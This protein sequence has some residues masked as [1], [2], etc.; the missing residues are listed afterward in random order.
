MTSRVVSFFERVFPIPAFLDVPQVGLD[1]S[2]A[3]IKYME[4]AHKGGRLSVKRFGEEQLPEG[5]MVAGGHIVKPDVLVDLLSKIHKEKKV[6]HAVLSLPEEQAYIVRLQV[7]F[8]DPSRI[9]EALELQLEEHIPL[10]P[11][12]VVF[13]YSILREPA[14]E[15]GTYDIA[16]AALPRPVVDAYLDLCVRAGIH[17]VGFEIETHAVSRAVVPV[18]S[19]ASTMVVDLGK[20]RTGI[21]IVLGQHVLFTSTVPLGG[22][23]ITK[24]V[25][26]EMHVSLEEAERLKIETGLS[27]TGDGQKLF[28][29]LVPIV[30]ALKDEIGKHYMYWRSHKDD[31]GTD[32]LP[33][34][35][36]LLCGGQASMPGLAEYLASD[37][38]VVVEAAQPWVNVQSPN[39][40]L[41]P[42][43]VR[44]A[45]RY[46]T[47]IGLALRPF[48]RES[49]D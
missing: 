34:E 26:R 7:P 38:G 2:D 4:L 45:L 18:A 48:S 20:T 30:S 14:D 35:K 23:A 27:R 1:I 5:A 21:A 31:A 28:D 33:I 37:L 39:V 8:M 49:H 10:P 16:V 22:D 17:A 46:T 19:R 24:A 15:K 36:I 43:S 44:E 42:L 47:A 25:E 3:S 32:H 9:H 41:P 40:A 11:H 12:D 6:D 13:D 29:F